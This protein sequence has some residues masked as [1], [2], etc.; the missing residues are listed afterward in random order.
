VDL[1]T[2]SE[3]PSLL[4]SLT[5]EEKQLLDLAIG[6]GAVW[7][8][9]V[10]PQLEAYLSPAN[11]LFYGGAAGGGKTDLLLGLALHAHRKSIIYRREY[12]QL[13]GIEER[14]RELLG[15]L[16]GVY[17]QQTKL[18]RHGSKVLELAAMQY[19]EDKN[20]FQGR[21]HDFY[22]F[23][24]LPQFTRAQYEFVIGWNRTT[25]KGQRCRVIG[26]GN[27]PLTADE[28]WVIEAWAPWLDS[29]HLDPAKPGELRWFCNL[30]GKLHW[31]RDNTPL[32]FKGEK[33]TLKSRTFI[34][35]RLEDNPH[36]ADTDYAATLDA[37]PEPMR[38]RLKHG[39]FTLV[40]QDDEFQL[41]PA[42]WVDAAMERWQPSPPSPLDVTAADVARGGPD[43]TVL[44]N[45]HGTWFA[46]LKKYAGSETPD[47]ESVASRVLL[48]NPK[49]AAVVV[50]EIGIGAGAFDALKRLG[51]GLTGFNSSESTKSRD[52]SGRLGFVNRRAE[53]WWKFREAL[54]PD[55]GKAIALP[56]DPELKSDLCA[57]RWKPVAGGKIQ[58]ESKDDIKTRIGRSTDC[59]DA[60]LMAWWKQSTAW[61]VKGDV[62]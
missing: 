42:S 19:D 21:P 1:P 33:R 50:D 6:E 32:E 41:I 5:D 2:T 58:V 26:A 10:G 24:E 27:P 39:L 61:D 22:G 7:L 47:G 53:M 34:P 43:K 56:P 38:S 11:E 17:N 3:L 30:E 12:P 35:A 20:K 48:I 18:L 51:F 14:M 62:A 45:R 29:A 15:S 46:P 57:P 16:E 59:A 28:E 36:L 23:D 9:V 60:V 52:R 8:P 44:A 40:R 25:S 37:M 54:D 4:A 13:R 49:L 31:Q 55:L